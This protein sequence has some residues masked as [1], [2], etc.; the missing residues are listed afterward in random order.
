MTTATNIAKALD[1][2]FIIKTTDSFGEDHATV[3]E[4][5]AVIENALSRDKE[6]GD[7]NSSE[8]DG[9]PTE[10]SV[11]K[12]EWRAMHELLKMFRGACRKHQFPN[13]P[14]QEPFTLTNQFL[15][16]IEARANIDDDYAGKTRKDVQP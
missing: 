7:A 10:G 16:E 4:L 12:R 13:I 9:C 3:E 11:L 8:M 6:T 5:L 2:E 14:I 1:E 15:N